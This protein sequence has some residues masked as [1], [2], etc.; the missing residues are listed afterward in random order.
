M[1]EVSDQEFTMIKDFIVTD[2]GDAIQWDDPNMD[3]T[4]KDKYIQIT[5]ILNAFGPDT[6]PQSPD[7]SATAAPGA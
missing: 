7:T 6:S 5:Q 1:V 4:L 2:L 3:Q